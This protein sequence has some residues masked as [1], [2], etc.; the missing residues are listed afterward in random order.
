MSAGIDYG[1]GKTNID[2]E[3]GIRYGV[4]PMHAVTQ[5]WADSSEA[6]YGN[7]HCP[8][9]GNEA[10]DYDQIPEDIESN[11]YCLTCKHCHGNRFRGGQN[12]VVRDHRCHDCDCIEPD[13]ADWSGE[14]SDYACLECK[15]SFMSDE[16][17]GDEPDCWYVDD[18]EIKATRRCPG[19]IFI[20]KSPYF[21]HAQ[22]CSPC[23]PGAGYLM[24]PCEDGPKTYCFG[25][26]W[27]KDG[28]APYPVFSVS[29]LEAVH[30]DSPDNRNQNQ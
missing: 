26:D 4:I 16:A 27:F 28:K 5:A 29:T 11:D 20:L 21:T 7:A 19:D 6:D 9:C 17:F 25:H 10:I 12:A 22:F 3:T 13:W 24:S 23:A 8:K 1:M 30:A 15:Y 2:K 18:G 14:G